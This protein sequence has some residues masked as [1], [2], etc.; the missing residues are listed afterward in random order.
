MD[1]SQSKFY[2]QSVFI[3][4]LKKNI[5]FEKKNS[6]FFF[7]FFLFN[8]G[9]GRPLSPYMFFKIYTPQLTWVLSGAFRVSSVVM[10][11]GFF[12]FLFFSFLLLSFQILFM[13]LFF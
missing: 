12:S 6:F 11:A 3:F 5:I 4:F 10:T 13:K 1:R 9:L 7:F 2:C 8:K